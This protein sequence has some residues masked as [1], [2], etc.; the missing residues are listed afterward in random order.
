MLVFSGIDRDLLETYR[1]LMAEYGISLKKEAGQ[2]VLLNAEALSYMVESA[3]IRTPDSVLEIGPGPGN[4]TEKLVERGPRQLTLV[5][6][7]PRFV[8]L[9]RDRFGGY[10]WIEI[11][12]GNALRI[13]PDAQHS[14]MVSNPP[15][16]ISSRLVV[17]TV[18]SEFDRVILTFQ[19]EFGRRLTAEP[20]TRSY[21][22]LSVLTQLRYKVRPLAILRASAFY[23]RPKVDTVMLRFDSRKPPDEELRLLKGLLPH[24]FANRKKT[25]R[26][27][28]KSWL[29]GFLQMDPDAISS[30]LESCPVPIDERVYKLSPEQYAKLASFL[31]VIVRERRGR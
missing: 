18:L 19:S 17:K 1:L 27:P 28:L 31:K 3:E 4:L 30:V 7:D 13:L 12:R 21:G 15:Y 26:A 25:L 2:H 5:E 9:L 29:R 11:V 16:G 23:P 10:E 22:S 24:I 8:R 14:V 6:R 20:G